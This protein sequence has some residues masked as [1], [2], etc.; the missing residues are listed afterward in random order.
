[1]FP[2]IL[3]VVDENAKVLFKDLVDLFGLA[4]GLRMI[5]SRQIHFDVEELTE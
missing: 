5:N 1:M 4:I 2:V 3:L